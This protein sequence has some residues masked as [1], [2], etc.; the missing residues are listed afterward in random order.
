[1]TLRTPSEPDQIATVTR[2]FG[3]FR[4]GETHR[5]REHDPIT[6]Q[7]INKARVVSK[8]FDNI[9]F[10]F[11]KITVE[12]PLRMN[13]QATAERIARLDTE[14]GFLK[15]ATSNKKN[16]KGRLAQI[17]AGVHRQ[18]AIRK[19]LQDFAAQHGDTPYTKRDTFLTDLRDIDHASNVRLTTPEIR[20]VLSAL[21]ERDETAEICYDRKGNPEPDPELRDTESVPFNESI[22]AYFER[23]VL[24][25]I[26]DA[27]IDESRTKVGYEIPLNRHFYQYQPPRPLEKIEA[28]TRPWS[29][30]YSTCSQ[31]SRQISEY[32]SDRR[33]FRQHQ[34]PLARPAREGSRGQ[35]ATPRFSTWLGV[36]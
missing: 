18:R 9:D 35:P 7:P 21:G 4:D 2:I 6:E 31:T 10:G 26:A 12:R 16:D 14:R 1:M 28:D 15:L 29:T 20:V 27:W 17:R 23:E 5:S 11:H 36:G 32:I 3:N 34:D 30:R 8:V 33:Q 24:S 19:L 13:F 22:Q 25:H